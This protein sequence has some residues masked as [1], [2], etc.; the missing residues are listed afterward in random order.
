MPQR[1]Q[2]RLHF[3]WGPDVT[4]SQ[5]LV[6]TFLVVSLEET[7]RNAAAWKGILITV[8]RSVQHTR[9]NMSRLSCPIL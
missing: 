9:R 5:E 4:L 8:L 7:W 1:I 6:P 2:E 3:F